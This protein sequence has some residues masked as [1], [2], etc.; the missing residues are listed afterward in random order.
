MKMP[1]G[2]VE[3]KKLYRWV[4]LS[5]L[6]LTA[7][8]FACWN[9][10][11]PGLYY[12]EMLFGNAAVGGKDYVFTFHGIPVLI[13]A[14]I[15]ALKSWI[16]YPIFAIFPVNYLSVRLPAILL[17]V[18][19]AIWLVAALWRGFGRNTAM[20]GAVMILLDPTIITHSRL[21]WGPNA[22][23][24]FFR[25]MLVYYIVKWLQTAK[26]ASAWLALAAMSFGLFDKLSFMWVAA[27][28]AA[29][30]IFVYPHKLRS[31]FLSHPAHATALAILSVEILAIGL[32]RSIMLT[33]H[34][35]IDWAYRISYALGNLRLTMSGGGALNCISGGGFKLEKWFW[36]GYLIA[37]VIAILGCISLFR[38]AVLRRLYIWLLTFMVLVTVAYISTRTATGAHHSSVMSGIWQMA[39]APLLG[40]V[41][42]DRNSWL[43]RFRLI[44]IPAALGLILAGSIVCNIICIKAWAYPTSPSWD[45]AVTR[46]AL[47][48]KEHPDACF[49]SSDWGIGNQVMTISK[50]HPRLIECWSQF[51]AREEAEKVIAGLPADKD[52]YIYTSRPGFENFKGNRDNLLNALEKNHFTHEVAMT[53]PDRN[54]SPMIE[55][56][57]IH[58]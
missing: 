53:Y 38:V 35:D 56:W 17:G 18:M 16:Y 4:F 24:F 15:G 48:A 43:K 8:T 52:V 6:V 33:E 39:L 55:I 36:P 57:K 47:F 12:D 54:G 9:I 10:S 3:N 13:M 29:A 2:S 28:A 26:P 50:G 11:Q 44:A 51:T 23:M 46:A 20:I 58:R 45:P 22:L 19:G 7:L 30:L 31:F 25:G 21:D 37:T 34:Q 32:I 41:L 42:D 14:Y 49:L 5:L 40:A 27:P 1:L